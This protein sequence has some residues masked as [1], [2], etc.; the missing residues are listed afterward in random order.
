MSEDVPREKTQQ[1]MM[2]M[3]VRAHAANMARRRI[4]SQSKCIAEGERMMQMSHMLKGVSP[5][6]VNWSKAEVAALRREAA[7][8][9]SAYRDQL[10]RNEELECSLTDIES[11]W[12]RK[13]HAGLVDARTEHLTCVDSLQSLL[14]ESMLEAQA[15]IK[16]QEAALSEHRCSANR[17]TSSLESF[18][19]QV[20]N[21]LVL[22]VEFFHTTFDHTKTICQ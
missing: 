8:L 7:T 16:Q 20:D 3:G 9:H 14:Q 11:C 10:M 21:R 19:I 13:L 6:E 2:G 4:A 22:T 18:L 15:Q 5:K 17:M 1:E 12:Q